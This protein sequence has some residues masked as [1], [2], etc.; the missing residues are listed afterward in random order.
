MANT[1]DLYQTDSAVLKVR[2]MDIDD[3]FAEYDEAR[4]V[5]IMSKKYT[6]LIMRSYTP[7][8]GEIDGS[9]DILLKDKE[10]NYR[11]IKAFYSFQNNQF[12]LLIKE[13]GEQNVW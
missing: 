1:K 13:K 5:R 12:V 11:N 8:I 2:I 4:L 9:V 6:I 10:I 7:T 3:G